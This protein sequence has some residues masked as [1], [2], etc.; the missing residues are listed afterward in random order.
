[1]FNN[2]AWGGYILYRSWPQETVFIDGQTDFYGEFLAREYTKVMAVDEGW[3]AT[4]KNYDV[5]WIIVPPHEPLVKALQNEKEWV[6]VYQDDTAA[7][8]REP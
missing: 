1:M 8:V 2:F 4:L 3:E 7:I 5:S 6:I